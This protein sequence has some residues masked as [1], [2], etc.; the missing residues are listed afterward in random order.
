MVLTEMRVDRGKRL[1]QGSPARDRPIDGLAAATR[2]AAGP[3]H[4]TAAR[5][6]RRPASLDQ[7]STGEQLHAAAGARRSASGGE[8]R[9]VHR[10]FE[11]RERIAWADDVFGP[12]IN[13]L[14]R[15]AGGTGPRRI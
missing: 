12:G 5:R 2:S 15:R 6:P 14:V 8:E 4:R 7:R 10:R 3:R 1:A 13:E 9:A 11:E